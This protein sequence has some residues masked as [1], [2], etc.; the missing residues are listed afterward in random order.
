MLSLLADRESPPTVADVAKTL[1]ARE[2]GAPIEAVPE[3]TVR[4]V[5]LALVHVHVPK[6]EADDAVARDRRRDTVAL[7]ERGKSLSAVAEPPEERVP[8]PGSN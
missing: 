8:T 3:R 1:A 6:L 4:C 2:H 7:T 5:Y